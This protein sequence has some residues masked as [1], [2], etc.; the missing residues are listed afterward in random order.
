MCV[1]VCVPPNRELCPVPEP[2]HLF[3]NQLSGSRKLLLLPFNLLIGYSTR[4]A[5]SNHNS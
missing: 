1:C 5:N 4:R 2:G 3:A